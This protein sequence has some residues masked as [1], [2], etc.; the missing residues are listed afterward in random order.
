MVVK[1]IQDVQRDI[2]RAE[3]QD[4]FATISKVKFPVLIMK[5]AMINSAS[6]WNFTEDGILILDVEDFERAKEDLESYHDNLINMFGVWQELVETK[7]RI[8]NIKNLKDK[9]KRHII[10]ILSSGKGFSL[11]E[12][13]ESGELSFRASPDQAGTWVSHASLLKVSHLTSRN[14]AEI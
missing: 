7:S 1:S 9:I 5:L 4:I 13:R 8:D 6:R 12:D 3:D 14:F 2:L 10:T 11:T